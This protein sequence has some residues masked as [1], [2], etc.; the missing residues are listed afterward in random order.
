MNLKTTL[1]SLIKSI[2]LLNELGSELL[3][4]MTNFEISNRSFTRTMGPLP[5]QNLTNIFNGQLV[6]TQDT[7]RHISV[8]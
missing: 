4:I 3:I 6:R 5:Y 8:D 1:V 7:N 2:C